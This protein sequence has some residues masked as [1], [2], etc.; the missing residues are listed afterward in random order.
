VPIETA[1]RPG[2][3]TAKI[4]S[5]AREGWDIDSATSSERRRRGT[6]AGPARICVIRSEAEGAAVSPPGK[7]KLHPGHT[8][9]TVLDETP[10]L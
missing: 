8:R 1:P 2:G 7:A 4:V 3:P 6:S 5:P 9:S 10:V